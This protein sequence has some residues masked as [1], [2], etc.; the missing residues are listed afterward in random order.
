MKRSFL[1]YFLL[2]GIIV[3]FSGCVRYYDFF[4][5]DVFNQG[6]CLNTYNEI[7]A[8]YLRSTRVYDQF[9]TIGSFDVLWLHNEVRAAY[10]QAYASQRCLSKERCN[11]FLR[12]QLEENNHFITFLLLFVIPNGCNYLLSSKDPIWSIQL[13]IDGNC[14]VPIEIKTIELGHEYKY[15][16][17]KTYRRF[18]TAYSVRFNA[19]DENGNALIHAGVR[20]LELQFRRLGHMTAV[21]WNLDWNGNVVRQSLFPPDILEYDL[22]EYCNC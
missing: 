2:L 22:Y 18:K 13:V 5:N 6:D 20:C 17:G 16:F 3:N 14:F 1:F 7:P 4:M 11:E 9:D 19:V 10:A 12:R 8:Q 21:S 15:F